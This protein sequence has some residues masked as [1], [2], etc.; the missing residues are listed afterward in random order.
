[1][2]REAPVD[3]AGAL[4]IEELVGPAERAG[5]EKPVV[6]GHGTRVRGLDARDAAEQG[7]EVPGVA[8]PQDGHQR[9]VPLSEGADRLLGD[10]LPALAPVTAR[11]A[12]LDREH[13]VEQQDAP[14]GP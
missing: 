11:L 13:P 2:L 1:S 6:R 8:A 9:R 3:R 12:R 5:A 7:S 14:L 4:A 10:L